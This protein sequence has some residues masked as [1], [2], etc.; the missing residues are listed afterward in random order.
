MSDKTQTY[1]DDPRAPCKY[2]I[3]CYQ[4]NPQHHQNF[5]H[6]PKNTKRQKDHHEP[7]KKRFK[8]YTSPRKDIEHNNI[9]QGLDH[10]DSK[11]D[12]TID[13]HVRTSPSKHTA[14]SSKID[15]SKNLCNDSIVI[16]L[17]ETLSYHDKDDQSL[18]KE[19]FLLEMPS[20]F[21]QLYKYLEELDSLEKVLSTV[22]LELI[23]PYDLLL[24]KLP[25][26]DDKELYLIHWRFFYDP[27]EF[28]VSKIIQ[29]Q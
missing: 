11:D 24:G 9:N 2:G 3:N 12:L 28:Q 10:E 18:F 4:K 19:L 26:L 23:G 13:E 20:D 5:K 16:K 25:K 15:D 27:P 22:N 21:F 14:S 17:P 29:N 1:R 8:P 7:N 6:L